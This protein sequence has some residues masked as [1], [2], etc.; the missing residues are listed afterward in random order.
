MVTVMKN[1]SGRSGSASLPIEKYPN[2][3]ATI[4]AAIIAVRVVEPA[5]PGQ[6]HHQREADAGQRRPEARLRLADAGNGVGGRDQPVEEDGLLEARLVVVVR[7]QPVA[8]LDHLA[9]R[10][11]VERFVRIADGRPSQARE[12]GDAAEQQ[13]QQGR[14]SH[15]ATIV[16]W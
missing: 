12:K 3:V 14:P 6:Q 9:R 7:R 4:A 11:G 10:L 1:A 15:G 8:A 13:Q 16:Y 5:P 2:A